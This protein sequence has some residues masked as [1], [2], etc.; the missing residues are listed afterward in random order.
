L[1]F[2]IR[3]KRKQYNVTQYQLVSNMWKLQDHGYPP[4]LQLNLLLKVLKIPNNHLFHLISIIRRCW[5]W[6]QDRIQ[7]NIHIVE[8]KKKDTDGKMNIMI[9]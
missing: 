3:I 4:E 9:W 8:K 7:N 1:A 6:N 5:W 2:I